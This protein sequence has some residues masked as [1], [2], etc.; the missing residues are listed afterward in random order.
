[1]TGYP[2]S[3]PRLFQRAPDDCFAT[4]A[5]LAANCTKVR[6]A[7][8]YIWQPPSRVTVTGDLQLLVDDEMALALTD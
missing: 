4:L 1:M 8:R 5:S 6:T 7:S 3:R 2:R